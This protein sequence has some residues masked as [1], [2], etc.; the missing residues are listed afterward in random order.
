MEGIKN[1]FANI[2][3][4]QLSP[5]H[6]IYFALAQC[7][8]Y[9]LKDQ[10]M[11]RNFTLPYSSLAAILLLTVLLGACRSAEKHLLQG[12]YDLAFEQSLQKLANG[13]V[14]DEEALVLERA[15]ALGLD[16]ELQAI[17]QM[18]TE[19]RPDRWPNIV[20]SYETLQYRINRVKP[21]LPL[22]I[23]SEGRYAV[24]EQP[25][26]T[27]PL[28]DARRQASIYY[29]T[30]ATRLLATGRKEDARLAWSTLSRLENDL[31]PYRDSRELMQKAEE[32]GTDHVA[33]EWQQSSYF[34]SAAAWDAIRYADLAPLQESWVQY[35]SPEPAGLN[36][37]FRVQIRVLTSFLS[38]PQQNELHFFETREIEKEGGRM[39]RD[40]SGNFV[41]VTKTETIRADLVETK[42]QQ[43]AQISGWMEITNAKTGQRLYREPVVADFIWLN[44]TL[45]ASGNLDALKPETKARLGGGVLPFPPPDMLMM[46]AARL[47][48]QTAIVQLANQRQRF[49]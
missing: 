30:E 5:F 18:K 46:D 13:K 19:S 20:R 34:L 6:C 32:L 48:G 22:Y 16:R 39:V 9:R 40:S 17:A 43:S 31:G 15:Y 7:L 3:N 12:N 27:Q 42:Q 25:D 44:S 1:S 24:I 41:M 36:P 23:V 26:L 29:Y 14:K 37:E 4:G 49:W 33:I 11:N 35:V 38:P 8:Q 45:R 10:A 21:F 28:A 2:R 47:F